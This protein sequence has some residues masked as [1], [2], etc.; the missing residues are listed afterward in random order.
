MINFKEELIKYQPLLEIEEIHKTLQPSS[1]KDLIEVVETIA[2]KSCDMDTLNNENKM[3]ENN[4]DE[5]KKENKDD[6][7]ENPKNEE[8]QV[9][10]RYE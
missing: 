1:M 3:K 4:K 10:K 6:N 8:K 9:G 5:N 7:K 2:M